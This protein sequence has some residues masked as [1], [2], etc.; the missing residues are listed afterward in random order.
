[1]KKQRL[2]LNICLLSLLLAVG[3]GFQPRAY[4][5][6][7]DNPQGLNGTPKTTSTTDPAS[8]SNSTLATLLSLIGRML[9]W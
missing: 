2:L 3:G 6:G 1:M 4:A 5:S 7:D 9:I 8:T